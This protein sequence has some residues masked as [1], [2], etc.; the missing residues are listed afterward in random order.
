MSR[1]LLLCTVLSGCSLYFGDGDD[2]TP[3]DPD[4]DPGPGGKLET[5][6]RPCIQDLV[7]GALFDGSG[8]ELFLSYQCDLPSVTMYVHVEGGEPVIVREAGDYQDKINRLR[9]V[10]ERSGATKSVVGMMKTQPH[11]LTFFQSGWFRTDVEN[12]FLDVRIA[13]LDGNGVRDWLVVGGDAIRRAPMQQAAGPSAIP[14]ANET[15]LLSGKPFASVVA[16]QL[17]GSPALDLLFVTATGEVGFALQTTPG[18]FEI[19]ATFPDPGAAPRPLVTA[20]VDGDGIEDVIGSAGHLFVRSSKTGTLSFLTEPVQ[21]FAV[22]DVDDDGVADALYLTADKTTVRRVKITA[23][24]S[25]TTELWYAG[26]GD[27]IAVGDLDGDTHGDIALVRDLGLAT[28]K[29]VIKL[30]Q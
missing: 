25:L 21:A 18:V 7:G 12:P 9:V 3:T 1:L 11:F 24:G 13:D 5:I 2:E 26:G 4:P 10:Q 14:A 6:E 28:S 8:D 30:A 20:D 29:L 19:S 16:A 23:S 17:G 22:G 27:A 15:V